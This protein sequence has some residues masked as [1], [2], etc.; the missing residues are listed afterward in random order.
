MR[1]LSRPQSF[2]FLGLLWVVLL[3]IITRYSVLAALAGATAALLLLH[4]V[5]A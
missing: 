2:L 4:G 1:R 3:A 5:L